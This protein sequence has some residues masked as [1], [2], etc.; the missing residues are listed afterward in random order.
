[1]WSPMALSSWCRNASPLSLSCC[2]R[3]RWEKMEVSVCP[4]QRRPKSLSPLP[5]Q[6]LTLAHR[7]CK[8]SHHPYL[9]WWQ[10][11]SKMWSNREFISSAVTAQVFTPSHQTPPAKPNTSLSADTDLAPW[12]ILQPTL[13]SLS[14]VISPSPIFQ[15]GLCN[16]L[17]PKPPSNG[18]KQVS[19]LISSSQTFHPPDS[20]SEKLDIR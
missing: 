10:W 9:C 7:T 11:S 4:K 12:C 1:M 19:L 8:I 13:S 6:P 3:E 17:I 18:V 14:E 2:A 16:L 5:A 20:Y 15:V